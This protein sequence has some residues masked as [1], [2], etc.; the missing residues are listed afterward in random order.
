M[1]RSLELFSGTGG[2]ALGL[3]KAGFVPAALIEWD[4]K[5]CNNINANISNGNKDVT[6]WKVHKTD[7]RDVT[8][9]DFGTDIQFVTG[10]PPCQPFSIGGKHKSNRDSRDMF[11]EA[12]RAVREI[13]PQGFIFENVRGLLRKSFSEYFNYILLQLSHPEIVAHDGID[14]VTHFKLLNEYNDSRANKSLEYNVV[15]KLMNAADYGVAKK[16][17]TDLKAV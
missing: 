17:E 5:S 16:R 8:F 15:F 12:I 7:I 10:G 3:H 14:W 1:I 9:T 2:L 11:P 6:G 13:Q 4:E